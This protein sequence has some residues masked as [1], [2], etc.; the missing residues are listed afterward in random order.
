MS[1]L[2]K[3][4]QVLLACF[5][6]YLVIEFIFIGPFSP[7]KISDNGSAIIPS[8][9]ATAENFKKFGITNWYPWMG[10][11]IDRLANNI[12]VLSPAFV[13]YSLFPIWA[14]GQSIQILNCLIAAFSCFYL[15]RY[16]LR[17]NKWVSF[18]C[19]VLFSF[20]MVNSNI[21]MLFGISALPAVL[22]ALDYL[23]NTKF[24]T[25][26][27]RWLPYLATG[28]IYGLCASLAHNLLLALPVICL[29]FILVIPKQNFSF[30]I[31]TSISFLGALAPHVITLLAILANVSESHRS[32]ETLPD[33]SIPFS[34]LYAYGGL[35]IIAF[36]LGL[37]ATFKSD[38][39]RF[40]GIVLFFL[41]LAFIIPSIDS[42]K[43]YLGQNFFKDS[44]ALISAI[45]SFRFGYFKLFAGLAGAFLCAVGLQA[46]CDVEDQRYKFLKK[47]AFCW[48][49]G[50]V[51][52][53]TMGDKAFILGRW[54]PIGTSIKYY[55]SPQINRLSYKFD[56]QKLDGL[57]RVAIV[58]DAI[59]RWHPG[60]VNTYSLEPGKT[61]EAIGGYMNLYPMRY[62][63][64]W[65]AVVAPCLA[66]DP[67]FLALHKWG[68][69]AY[70]KSCRF[71]ERKIVAN[72][73][74]NQTLLSLS[75]VKYFVSQLPI[76]GTG[77]RLIESSVREENLSWLERR[78]V[79][80]IE[81]IAGG[82]TL[83]I[84]E[85]NDAKPRA[86]FVKG[87]RIFNTQQGLFS[88]LS[89][90]TS[91][92]LADNIY[93]ESTFLDSQ[94]TDIELYNHSSVKLRS[95]SPDKIDLTVDI[96]GSGYLVITNN[97][98]KYWKCKAS[99]KTLSLFPAYGTFWGMKLSNGSH[100][101]ECRY[102]PHYAIL[103]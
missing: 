39:R 70:L 58:G 25:N 21:Y 89:Q 28:V 19:A 63:R 8:Y 59:G 12:S 31:F 65:T 6:V 60:F 4:P 34:N 30:W 42:L 15:S 66:H 37:A 32:D 45:K 33:P 57:W 88:A 85:N 75:N 81:N 72:Q 9:V 47:I 54:L 11:G 56:N 68:H 87:L 73:T 5:S 91:K 49:G 38:I 86:F 74:F 16:S 41:L 40:S 62:K 53:S 77:L 55:D 97:Y 14:A 50:V 23:D 35:Y 76:S 7:F 90:A 52:L 99:G 27:I 26:K 82:R 103:K 29:W 64:F 96:S 10:A 78:L 61:M 2:S 79:R 83:Y 98:S 13:L 20:S 22:L 67:N 24:I 71:G 80:P 101:V 92:D 94:D 43:F 36:V 93:V 100:Q 18:T 48:I 44:N 1:K 46:L 95:Y 84:Y 102:Q 51:V 17:L 3:N 69:K